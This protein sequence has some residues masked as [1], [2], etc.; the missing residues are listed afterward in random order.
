MKELNEQFAWSA[1]CDCYNGHNSS[2]GRCTCRNDNPAN[3]YRYG[4]LD[5]THKPGEAAYCTYCREH[6]R[7][8]QEYLTQE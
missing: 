1:R 7:K 5:Q 2:S 4:V 3:D 8:N 6:C